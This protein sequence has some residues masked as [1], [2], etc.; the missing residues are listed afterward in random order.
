[1]LRS[2]LIAAS[3]VVLCA[4]S[5]AQQQVQ[6]RKI[7]SPVR[8]AGIYHVATGTW[9]RTG[10]KANL[11]PDTIYSAT[12]PSGYF[13]TGWEAN[14]GIDEGMLPGTSSVGT[15]DAYNIDGFA[16]SYCSLA[17]TLTWKY[18]FLSSYVPCDLYGADAANCQEV[19]GEVTVSGLPTGG[20]CWIV[21]IDLAG[22]GEI[23]IESD[24][25]SCAPGYQ[26]G[27]LDLDHFGIGHFWT[28]GNGGTTGPILDGYDPN[29]A[30][31]GDGT[32]YQT[33]TTCAAGNTARGARDFFAIDE[34]AVG[35]GCYWF[36]GYNNTNGCGGPSQGPAAQFAME[37]FTDCAATCEPGGGDDC[38][39]NYCNDAA[40]GNEGDLTIDTCTVN[41][42]PGNTLTVSNA[43]SAQFG[44]A[45]IAAGQGAISNPP[46]AQGTLCVGPGGIGRY[47]KDLQ[48]TGGS[49]GYDVNIYDSVTGGG[50][51][52]I[53]ASAGGGTLTAGDTWNFQCWNR[54]A[55][56]STFTAALTVTFE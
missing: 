38:A 31:F 11:G 3:A 49:G 18:E 34:G 25:G 54:I 13:G 6:A 20:G 27:G 1:M 42:G 19:A 32:C 28:T 8:D 48:A 17:D 2:S 52:G 56:S 39:V 23:C 21:T 22:G 50:G 35:P 36:G 47:V 30:P 5:S 24:G 55:G 41:G 7:I 12:A 46:G 14:L 9:T 51:G 43:P 37:L 26:G 33:A 40:D 44:Y 4:T 29:W 10:S 45:M 53:P 16:F 15:Q